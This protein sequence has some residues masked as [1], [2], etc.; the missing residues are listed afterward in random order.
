M[1][2]LRRPWAWTLRT[3]AG[4]GLYAPY[5]WRLCTTPLARC[6]QPPLQGPRAQHPVHSLTGHN[7]C[8]RPWF[9]PH[10]PSSRSGPA[11]TLPEKRGRAEWFGFLLGCS[12]G[13]VLTTSTPPPLQL[14]GKRGFCG[15]IAPIAPRMRVCGRIRAPLLYR[16]EVLG[17]GSAVGSDGNFLAGAA[18]QDVPCNGAMPLAGWCSKCQ[19]DLVWFQLCLSEA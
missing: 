3:E 16:E 14:H 7:H 5:G 6:A 1:G 11:V 10:Q 12:A 18:G 2:P 13:G 17:A 19:W 15:R 8:V 4:H 9:T